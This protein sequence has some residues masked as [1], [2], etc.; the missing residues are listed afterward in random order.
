MQTNS[1]FDQIIYHFILSNPVLT[2]NTQPDFFTNP[3]LKELYKIAKDHVLKYKESPSK[4]QIQQLVDIKGISNILTKEIINAVYNTKD[5]L[6]EYD[7]EWLNTNAKAWIQYRNLDQTIRKVLAYIKTTSVTPE[8]AEDVVENVRRM[9]NQE[10]NITFEDEDGSDFFNPESHSQKRLERSSTGY[11]YIDTCQKG[12]NWKG[13]FIVYIAGPKS[14]KSFW[15]CNLAAEAVKQ[16]KNVAYITLELQEELVAMR[17]GA[18]LLNVPLDKYEEFAKDM[19]AVKNK[20]NQFKNGSLKSP[21][22]LI[23]KEFP[24]SSAGAN[25]IE[26]YLR[27]E[28]ERLG[29]KFDEVYVDYM[30]IMKNSKMPNSENTYLKLKTITEDLRAASQ[31]NNWFIA[32]VCQVNRTGMDSTDIKSTDISESIAILHGVDLCYALI[33]SP[34]MK[35]AGYYYIKCLADRVAPYDNTRKKFN[36][37]WRYGRI[38]EDM[39]SDIEDFES[40]ANETS[41]NKYRTTYKRKQQSKPF[42]E[43]TK[44][45]NNLLNE[46]SSN[47]INI[48]AN[49][50]F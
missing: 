1:Y 7:D 38:T 5:L 35:A 42:I 3:N 15:L 29:F 46:V 33:T 19:S 6:N 47:I 43:E 13:S 25:D 50:L 10:T 8:N 18:N 41:G 49:D 9:I 23:I 11:K 12:G 44:N 26:L 4:E 31:R 17:I 27:K 21:G 36:I 16:G 28:E 39:N 24:T 32:S 30:S 34:E 2:Q 20:L 22:K 48:T 37:D 45:N 14:G 40:F